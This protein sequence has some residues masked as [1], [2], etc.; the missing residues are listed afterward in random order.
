M[1]VAGPVHGGGGGSGAWKDELQISQLLE[2]MCLEKL[3]LWGAG[4]WAISP[5]RFFCL[6][7]KDPPTLCSS[8]RSAQMYW[9]A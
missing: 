6:P 1:Q 2:V 4:G 3:W 7:E 9:G 5:L 8:F